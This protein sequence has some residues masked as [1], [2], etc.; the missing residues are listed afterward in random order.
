LS[1]DWLLHAGPCSRLPRSSVALQDLCEAAGRVSSLA[2]RH[3]R[4]CNDLPTRL[5][6][7]SESARTGDDRR[8]AGS[9]RDSGVIGNRTRSL[10]R[11]GL[12]AGP[13]VSLALL[14]EEQ[15]EAYCKKVWE[16]TASRLV[17]KSQKTTSRLVGT[18][19]MK[20]CRV[21]VSEQMTY[22][23]GLV[24]KLLGVVPGCQLEQ[25][26]CHLAWEQ[27]GLPV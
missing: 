3:C 7:A 22:R 1:E 6:E 20:T 12:L 23:P 15:E 17:E 25:E 8:T 26:G 11:D 24:R 21:L 14:Q 27:F 18:E 13:A 2:Y 9:Y 16:K 19:Q 5:H 10:H 4:R